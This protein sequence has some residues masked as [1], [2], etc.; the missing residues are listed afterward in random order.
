MAAVSAGELV[1]ILTT[2][3]VEEAEDPLIDS[4]GLRGAAVVVDEEEGLAV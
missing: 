2:V 3:V 1:T 4:L